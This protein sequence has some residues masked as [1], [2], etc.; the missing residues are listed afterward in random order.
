MPSDLQ[1]DTIKDGSASNTLF[2]Q[3]GSDWV[4]GSAPPAGTILQVK[5][6]VKTDKETQ[7]FSGTVKDVFYFVPAQGGSGVFQENITITGSN[8]VLIDAR[9]GINN[10]TSNYITFWAI[11]RGAATDTVI[12]S[13]TKIASGDVGSETGQT[14]ATGTFCI[15]TAGAHIDSQSMLWLDSPGAG[16]YYY[17]IAIGGENGSTGTFNETDHNSDNYLNATSAS[18]LTLME[19][20]V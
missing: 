13:C 3:S 18:S 20:A 5:Q 6:T 14:S 8:K 12:G 2:E 1:V 15:D 16:T 4:W 17:K 19:V 11:F 9:V 7:A 10:Q